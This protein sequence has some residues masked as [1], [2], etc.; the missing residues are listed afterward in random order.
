MRSVIERFLALFLLVVLSPIL[1]MI[2]VGVWLSSPGPIIF[3]QER[4]GY[5]SKPFTVYKFRGMYDQPWP[6]ESILKN[7]PRV[8]GFGRFIRR[9]HLDELPQLWN[10]VRGEMV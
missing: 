9:T 6:V 4:I 1:V 8:T 2:A 10:V 7:D 3:R 5:Q